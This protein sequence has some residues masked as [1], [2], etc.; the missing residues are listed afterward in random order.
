MNKRLIALLAATTITGATVGTTGCYG[1]FALTKKLHTWNGS[2][3]NKFLNTIVF[4][5]LVIIPVYELITLGDAIIFNLIEFWTGSNPLGGGATAQ[6]KSESEDAVV[7]QV[8]DREYRLEREAESFRV[9]ADGVEIGRGG[10]SEDGSLV[11]E[12][13]ENGRSVEVRPDELAVLRDR[14][15]RPDAIPAMR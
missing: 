8:G 10:L 11:L 7:V 4:W 2:L 6:V 5:V 13:L 14:F 9:L 15:A 1:S 12:D 3:G